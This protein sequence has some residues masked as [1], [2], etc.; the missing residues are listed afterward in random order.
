MIAD[1]NQTDT[2][3]QQVIAALEQSKPLRI[4]G[5]DS[6]AFYG[7]E[8]GGLPL[9]TAAHTGIIAY[10]PSELAV[11]VRTGT[12]LQD[13][14]ALLA[15]Q[16]QMLAFEPPCLGPESTIGGVV[17][18]GLSGPARPW[19]GSV[20][21]HILGV[22][23]VTGRGEI[24]NF[25][26]RV[27]KNVAGYDVSRLMVGSLGTL[28][29]MLDVSLKVLPIPN[30]EVTVTLELPDQAAY[31][32]GAQLRRSAAPVTASCY[33]D[34]CLYVRL[35]GETN[36]VHALRRTLG[37]ELLI[38]PDQFWAALRNQTHEFFQHHARPLWRLS[39][40]PATQVVSRL[41]GSSM[42][43]WGGAQRWIYSNIPVNLIRSIAEKYKGHA[44][45]YRGNLPGVSTFHPLP[46]PMLYLQ[47]RLKRSLD[48]HGIFSPGR[49]Y[50]DC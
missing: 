15:A 37:G 21:D 31:E 30:R 3:H 16:G 41:E 19:R 17:A 4:V 27:M 46:P 43:E 12:R 33:F 18:S 32:L 45:L 6:K 26:G 20:R 7:N 10:E 13:L 49:L 35:S 22:N 38:N 1:N 5:S 14:E 25:G 2:L 29:L 11:T 44:T 36:T 39:F 28:G 34:G 9:P 8:T 47:Q 24:A 48:P 40:P 23:L 50:K 42:I